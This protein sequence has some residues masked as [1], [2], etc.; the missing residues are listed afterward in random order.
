MAFCF[1][2][3]ERPVTPSVRFALRAI[4]LWA[5]WL[6]SLCT[7]GCVPYPPDFAPPTTTRPPI[8]ALP[9]TDQAIVIV[10]ISSSLYSGHIH[11][12]VIVFDLTRKSQF[13]W[14][15]PQE[16]LF[17]GSPVGNERRASW[18]PETRELLIATRDSGF[19][20]Q[21]S[22]AVR[23]LH[24][25]MPGKLASFDGI[26][27]LSISPDGRSLAYYL[28]TRDRTDTH[29][30]EFG[31]LYQDLMYQKAEASMP[32]TLMRERRPSD[33]SWRPDG[34]AI[35]FGTYDGGITVVDTS[36][37]TLMSLPPSPRTP[38]G[39]VQTSIGELRWAPDGRQIAFLEVISRRL[40][41]VDSDGSHLRQVKFDA[42][43][44]VP[45]YSFAWSPDGG[46]FAL[47]TT[48]RGE[49]V[50]GFGAPYQF[51]FQFYH[52]EHGWTVFTSKVDGTDLVR[53]SPK[54]DWYYDVRGE[55]FW[56]Q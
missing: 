21:P 49:K 12:H 47:L 50:C 20:V 14:Q 25:A 42:P 5:V 52:C 4:A 33:I 54:G 34:G 13:E 8:S 40:Y 56:V 51:S 23:A 18:A 10:G 45:L 19:L 32:R 44:D 27:A 6:C 48:Y 31:R 28:Y 43:A 55:L 26:E 39:Y 7:S 46:R 38:E 15:L 11:A 29:T 1:A 2:N 3:I 16:I 24:P 41:V 22:G 35:A 37:K 17:G 53:V 9:G 30:D 36:G